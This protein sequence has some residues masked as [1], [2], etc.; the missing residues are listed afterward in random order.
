VEGLYCF[1]REI[2]LALRFKN[3]GNDQK[4]CDGQQDVGIYGLCNDFQISALT[5][6][7]IPIIVCSSGGD[8]ARARE[9]GADDCLVHP[10]LYD[11]FSRMLETVFSGYG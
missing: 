3:H 4:E 9:C 1:S 5:D 6:Q 10:F 8:Q 2:N 7:N 11:N